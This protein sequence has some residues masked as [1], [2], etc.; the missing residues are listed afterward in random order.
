MIVGVLVGILTVGWFA[1][2]RGLAD[3][4]LFRA[5]D[6]LLGNNSTSVGT[7]LSSDTVS[8]GGDERRGDFLIL[9]NRGDP[10]AGFDTMRTSSIALHHVAG[11]LFGPG[12]LVMRCR[13]NM[14]LVCPY[15][16]TRW[17]SSPSFTE[18]TFTLRSDVLWHDGARF[19]AEDVKFWL[20]L[21]IWGVQVGD[22][23]R[24]PAYFKGDLGDVEKVEAL[25]GDQ[26]RITLKSSNRFLPDILADPRIKIAHPRHLMEPLIAEGRVSV[27]PLDIGLIG[28]GPFRLDAYE[29]GTVVKLLRFDGYFE[30]DSKG[31]RLPYLDGIHYIIM[32]DPI[33]MD[34]AFRAGRLDGGARGFGHYLTEER[35]RGY[36][37]DLGEEVFFAQIEGG[38]FRIA[39]NVMKDGPWQDERVRRAIA[40]W[41]DKE[42]AI[43]AVLGGFG[44]TSPDISPQNPHKDK[45]FVIWP[46]FD[47]APLEEKRAEAKRLIEEA[48]Y[49]QGFEM[50]HLCRALQPLGCQFLKDQF[51]GLGID[52]RLEIRDEA[53]WNEARVGLRHDSQQGALSVLPIP[54]GTE[55]VYGRFS[56]NPDAY[57]KHEDAKV[58]EYYR[59]LRD[60]T[61][62]DRRIG[63][64]RELQRYLFV[65][66]TYIVPIAE[67]TYVVAYRTYVKGLVIPPEDGHTHTDF[68]TVWL[69]KDG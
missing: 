18:W 50:G 58:D 38:T 62:T 65:E 24:A 45:R 32:P 34:A 44:W 25:L 16:A 2:I 13:E 63:I 29:R 23:V 53:Q 40:L 22:R 19:T 47:L 37:D 52:L 61:T 39:F 28:L 31:N 36:V 68:A 57:S 41:V 27:T 12:N 26:V 51:A 55:G 7:V 35:M 46:T 17:F 30:Y 3:P 56:K 10:P 49:A 59:L 48:G 14:Y 69:D 6:A 1:G 5:Q 11:A 20:D 9:A 33:S 42:A 8:P 66:Q 64:W 54:E 15:L 60:A 4:S 21:A 43:P 67:A